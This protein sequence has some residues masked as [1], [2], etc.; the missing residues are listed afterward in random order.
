MK[1]VYLVIALLVLPMVG[2]AQMNTDS[3][4]PHCEFDSLA[5]CVPQKQGTRARVTDA[6][7]ACE[8]SGGSTSCIME[9]KKSSAGAKVATAGRIQ[10][11]C[12]KDRRAD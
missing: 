11:I 9:Y 12:P 1:L 8:N 10:A 2:K 6:D 4:L 3:L 7:A 5:T